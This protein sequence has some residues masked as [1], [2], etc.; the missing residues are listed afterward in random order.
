LKWGGIDG[1]DVVIMIAFSSIFLSVASFDLG[2]TRI[3]TSAWHASGGESVYLELEFHA[4][5]TSVYVLIGDS[6]YLGLHL[7]ALGPVGLVDV[8]FLG[9]GGYYEWKGLDINTTTDSLMMQFDG[10]GD[11]NEIVMI[12]GT[13]KILNI[14]QIRCEGGDESGVG[15][16]IDEQEYFEDPPTYLSETYF[17]EIYYVKTAQQ[18][19]DHEE[20]FEWTHPPLGK[21]IMALGVSVFGFSPFGWRFFGVLSATLMI[22]I[23]YIFAKAMFETRSAAVLAASL[24]TLDFLHF[25]M[26][27][28]GTVDT[29]LV[30]FT[31][32]S[33]L[34]FYM[35]FHR[36]F[37]ERS[38]PDYKFIFLG[39]VFFSLALSVKWTALYGFVGQVFL[40]LA[41]GLVR[42]V[43]SNG[44]P[45]VSVRQFKPLI[46]FLG[47]L[48]VGGLIYLASFVP[49][50]LMGHSFGDVYEL[51]WQM[52]SYHAGLFATH[53]FSSEWWTW[54]LDIRP[55]WLYF[56]QLPSG[57]VSTITAMG[58]PIIW[59]SGLSFVLIAL[60]RG[61]K[62]RSSPYLYI[63]LI[64]LFQWL[65]YAPISRPLFIYH[66][67]PNVPVLI[68]ASAG[69][70]AESWRDRRNRYFVLIF[71]IVS[72]AAFVLFYPVISGYPIPSWYRESLRWI[73]SWAF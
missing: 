9:D 27:R 6:D 1:R 26:A 48:I 2:L 46:I 42:L 47:F 30:L 24:L 43:R 15:R 17:D 7:Y 54:P 3:P 8:G 14:S 37:D 72:A 31:L 22:P 13:K 61:L 41:V 20:P 12:D 44:V 25:T 66:Y 38:G 29:Y 68:L 45:R 23:I 10:S 50:M 62:K 4:H 57:I 18:Y 5:V 11:I 52:Y 55:V 67:Y 40:L 71:L 51:Q 63:G 49:Y 16:L 33:S 28:I 65:P 35:S 53:P 73:R 64:F 32:V 19:L 58:N 69:L 70:L 39:I 21:L 59:W 60:W 36:I 34:F 56:E